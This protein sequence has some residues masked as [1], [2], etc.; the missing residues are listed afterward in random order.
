MA[1]ALIYAS[2][3]SVLPRYAQYCIATL[4]TALPPL[5]IA[6]HVQRGRS[7]GKSLERLIAYC[8]LSIHPDA[9][10][11]P[12]CRSR[13]PTVDTSRRVKSSQIESSRVESSRVK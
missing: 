1:I 11:V 12:V 8:R 7:D 6:H 10:R 4:S 5:T 3:R 13:D 2:L 9:Q